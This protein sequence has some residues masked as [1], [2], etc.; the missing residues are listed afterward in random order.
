M[1]THPNKPY[2][3]DSILLLALALLFIFFLKAWPGFYPSRPSNDYNPEFLPGD[4]TPKQRFVLEGAIDINSAGIEEF[5]F[6]PGIGEVLAKKII[7][8]RKERGGFSSLEELKGVKGIGSDRFEKIRRYITI[9]QSNALS[10]EKS[11]GQSG[12]ERHY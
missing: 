4:A 3:Y 12:A 7:E 10:G 6:L 11:G 9:K 2:G 8:K 1:K 5:A